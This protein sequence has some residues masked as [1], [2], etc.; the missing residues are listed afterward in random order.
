[1]NTTATTE[2]IALISSEASQLQDFM[3][4][5]EPQAWSRPSACTGWTVG[6]V[7]AHV[8][9]GADTWS[10]TITRAMAGDANPPPGQRMLRPG[11]RGSEVTA[12]RAIAL[13][14]EKGEQALLQVFTAGY[15]RLHQ[16]LLQL[17]PAD[18]DK[19]CFH[20][21]GIVP[22]R[23]YVGIRLQELTIHSWDIRSAFDEAATLSEKPLPVLL[24][25]AQRWLANT[26]SPTPS[27]AAPV[28]YRF[29]VSGPAAVRQ[30]VL[31]SQDGFC[32]EPVAATGA[33][34]TFRCD[35]GDYILLVYGRLPLERALDTGRLKID[36]SR[37]QAALFNTLF[38]GV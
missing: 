34:V 32:I 14:Q 21:R 6:D 37:E 9:Q 31:V 11:E 10:E 16:I 4:S 33:D 22:T 8:T 38:R 35:T 26:F 2:V 30:D 12:Q 5:L 36:G 19:P 3:A 29:D 25:R 27:L 15:D 23:D 20:R 18:W 1:M 17:Q 24:E 13:R 7:F 28:R